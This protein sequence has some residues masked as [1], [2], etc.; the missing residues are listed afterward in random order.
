MT[1]I[2]EHRLGTLEQTANG[3]QLRY[4]RQLAKPPATVWKA[5]TDPE[6]I[7]RWFPSTIEGELTAGSPLTF[8]IVDYD[9]E[10]FHGQVIEVDEPRL[11]VLKWGPDVLRFE[12]AAT[13]DGT[14]L[15]MTVELEALGKASRDGA[16]WHETLDKLSVAMADPGASGDAAVWA[17]VHPIYVERF[18]PEAS[19]LGPPQEY[20]DAQSQ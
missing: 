20:L 1:K 2:D 4:T 11:L 17:D 7:A 8:N 6:M 14:A 9:T 3:W 12:L 18:G 19:T 15:T 16:G 5:F 10:P 13:T